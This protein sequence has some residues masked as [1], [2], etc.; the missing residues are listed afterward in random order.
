MTVGPRIAILVGGDE[1][2]GQ[3]W[4]QVQLSNTGSTDVH[5]LAGLGTCDALHITKGYF[6][7]N[8]RHAFDNYDLLVNLIT[9][10]DKNSAVLQ[11]LEKALAGTRTPVLNPP[12]KVRATTRDGVAKLLAGVEHLLVPRVRKLRRP[13]AHVLRGLRDSGAMTFPAILRPAGTHS[14]NI[15]SLIADPDDPIEAARNAADFYLT[16]FVDFRSG[17][18]LYRKYRVFVFGGIPVFRHLLISDSW[19]VHMADRD[20]FMMSRPELLA[21]SQALYDRGVENFPANVQAIFR[22]VAERLGLDFFGIDFGIL[23]DGR[24]VL[25]EANAT[26]NFFPV[27]SDPRLAAM[28]L[29]VPPAQAA[30]ERMIAQACSD[31][32]LRGKA[33]PSRP[34]SPGS[35]APAGRARA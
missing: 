8:R 1:Q 11:V 34:V 12:A 7:Q 24:A 19:N 23:P 5:W 28:Q 20:R 26:M 6:R 16:E 31:A 27:S 10:A 3:L 18:G 9:D 15:T 17:D 4:D 33:D 29:C 32:I 13:S 21:E 22:S 30:F 25:F 35:S 14:G 2:A